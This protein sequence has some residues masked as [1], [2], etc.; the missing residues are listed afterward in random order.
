MQFHLGLR[1]LMEMPQYDQL[2]ITFSHRAEFTNWRASKK[3][4]PEAKAGNLKPY[5]P[6][7]ALVMSFICMSLY[8]HINIYEAFGQ[9]RAAEA[10]CWH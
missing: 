2:M 5:F 1:N 9:A 7:K 4:N 3:T 10:A 8:I 6:I